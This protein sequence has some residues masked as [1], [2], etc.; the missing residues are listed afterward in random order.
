MG[1]ANI[2]A[3]Y[4][5]GAPIDSRL[6]TVQQMRAM[7]GDLKPDQYQELVKEVTDIDHHFKDPRVA[8]YTFFYLMD[9]CIM[10]TIKGV[11]I[12]D[13]QMLDLLSDAEHKASKFTIENEWC[14]ATDGIQTK[15][16]EGNVIITPKTR[17]GG[18][19][20]QERS[21]A[22]YLAN[23]DKTNQEIVAIF[24]KELDM[25]KPG[26]TTYVYNCK[27]IHKASVQ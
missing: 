21:M 19:T 27:K 2:I 13:S 17:K 14:F 6:R 3:Q 12:P 25:S 24:M 4:N 1:Y 20:K 7:H 9:A 5:E 23:K 8:K 10:S 18:E 15:D 11:T 16:D 26:A 22:L